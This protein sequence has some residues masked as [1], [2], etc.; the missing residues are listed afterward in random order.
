[1]GILALNLFRELR[2]VEIEYSQVV[3]GPRKILL[4]GLL[5]VLLGVLRVWLNIIALG[6]SNA[7]LVYVP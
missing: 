2:V 6:T 7:Y 4:L 3:E 1:M 5:V